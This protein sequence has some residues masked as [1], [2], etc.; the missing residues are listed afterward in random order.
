[1]DLEP[2]RPG[3]KHENLRGAGYFDP[4]TSILQQESPNER[5]PLC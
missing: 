1:M 4:A 5:K 3:P 2:E